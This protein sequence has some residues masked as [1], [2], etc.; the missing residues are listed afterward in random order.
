M[1]GHRLRVS[2]SF[3]QI[4][5][6]LGIWLG[7]SCGSASKG[8]TAATAVPPP[9][10]SAAAATPGGVGGGQ[11]AWE[12]WVHLEG[13]VDIGGPRSDGQLVVMA[14]G[15]LFLVAPDRT[16]TPFARGAD[17]YSGSA[18]GEPYFVVVPTIAPAAGCPFV[19]DEVFI[20][21]LGSPPG[22]S[23]VETSGRA[24]H[25]TTIPNVDFLSGIAF[26]TTGRFGSG[27]LVAGQRD[28]KTT[29][30]AVD[31]RGRTSIVTTTAPLFEGGLA[32]APPDFGPYAGDLFGP[33]ELTGQLWAIAPDGGFSLVSTP[34]LPTGGDTG[35]ESLGFVPPGFGRSGYAYL[36]DRGTVDNAFPGT[37]SILRLSAATIA[38][39]GARAGDLLVSTEGNGLTVGLRCEK[40]C[41]RI[42]LPSGPAGAHVEGHIVLAPAP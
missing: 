23:R 17:G 42:D 33:D 34:D 12:V 28:G 7:S 20:L 18:D 5:L 10:S 38:D 6:V 30:A 15:R 16:V 19:R 39:R 14:A 31:C 27:I 11:S 24:S 26:D 8:D 9:T 13:V 3:V 2:R 40:A 37:D 32:V 22:L 21:D 35:I 29:V 1:A 25:F 4:V 41:A 36:A